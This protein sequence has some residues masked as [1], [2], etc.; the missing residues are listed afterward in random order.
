MGFLEVEGEV[1]CRGMLGS[2]REIDENGCEVEDGGFVLRSKTGNF[3][4][5]EEGA[6][7]VRTIRFC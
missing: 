5:L 4:G 7:R 3:L 2:L 6:G 1:D